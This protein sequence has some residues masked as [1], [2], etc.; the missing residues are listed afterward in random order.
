MNLDKQ[1][2]QDVKDL[3][4]IKYVQG[5][6]E[7]SSTEG[8][9]SNFAD[10]EGEVSS[11][12]SNMEDKGEALEATEEVVSEETIE[13]K[14]TEEELET[15]E[16]LIATSVEEAKALTAIQE[17]QAEEEKK[18]EDAQ[19]Q[20]NCDSI[21]VPVMQ[22][23]VENA[24]GDVVTDEAL[25]DVIKQLSGVKNDP[26]LTI[27]TSQEILVEEVVEKPLATEEE[28]ED[29]KKQLSEVAKTPDLEMGH[30]SHAFLDEK[31]EIS[32]SV[33]GDAKATFI[34]PHC[35]GDTHPSP[36]VIEDEDVDIIPCKDSEGNIKGEVKMKDIRSIS[37]DKKGE[38]IISG[39]EILWNIESPTELYD[40]FYEIKK[41]QIQ[42]FS[43]G[44]QLDF[45]RLY[46]DLY[47]CNVDISTEVLDKDILMK[48]LDIVVQGINRVA[49]IQVQVNH[50]QFVWKRFV[51]LLRGALARVQ[52]LKPVLKQ[53]GLILEH[54]GDIEF[55][56]ERL[57]AIKDSAHKIMQS[58]ERAFEAVSRKVS[59]MLTVQT[60]YT[61]RTAPDAYSN[62]YSAPPTYE[63]PVETH[64]EEVVQP[65]PETTPSSDLGD[66]DGF[67]I[68]AVVK[69]VKPKAGECGWGDVW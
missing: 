50:Q 30:N 4:D 8:M 58:L 53:E 38:P 60:K 29:V 44:R 19:F 57:N 54:M 68:G 48:H 33:I 49:T 1:A 32:P 46:A 56:V 69:P 23:N 9:S 17:V 24:N 40:G 35:F 51:E 12:I 2:V 25:E 5:D 61:E 36:S 52:Y 21:E 37:W 28:T 18:E 10:L 27:I 11:I 41:K 13:D 6:E 39:G 42:T 66:Y 16:D 67:D 63:T 55:Y 7:S 64:E 59:V 31:V 45:E 20:D 15:I 65:A 43:G 26:D 3:F 34:I 22:A 47:A 62:T 14:E